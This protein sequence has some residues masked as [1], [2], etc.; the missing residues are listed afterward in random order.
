MGGAVLDVVGVVLELLVLL[1]VGFRHFEIEYNLK[2]KDLWFI[3]QRGRKEGVG[4]TR[5]DT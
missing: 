3:I 5:K 1:E 2:I 4:R